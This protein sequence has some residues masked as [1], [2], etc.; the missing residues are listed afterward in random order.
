MSTGAVFVACKIP[1]GLRAQVRGA[2]RA[3]AK[4][5]DGVLPGAI[6]AEHVFKGPVRPLNVSPDSYERDLAQGSYGITEGVP[7]DFWAE[8]YA[9][10]MTDQVVVGGYVFAAETA[11]D[12]I[13]QAK[14]QRAIKSGMEPADPDKPAPGIERA[15]EKS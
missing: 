1:N 9:N 12:L 4:P 5:E 3:M 6:R 15:T 2:V 11:A 10:N 7:A 13:A 8:W 14:E